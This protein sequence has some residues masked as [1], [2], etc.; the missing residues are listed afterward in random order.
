MNL[1]F[2]RNK[3]EENFRSQLIGFLPKMRHFALG[4]V[5]DSEKADDLVQEACEIALKMA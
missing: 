1:S 3:Q 5:C 2:I 4:L